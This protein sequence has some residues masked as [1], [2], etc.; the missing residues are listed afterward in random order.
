MTTSAESSA[1]I[2]DELTTALGAQGVLT[3]D[4][5]A[6]R[7]CT[8]WTG[9]YS[10]RP[11]AVLRPADT[12]GVAT[13]VRLC[14]R[15]GLA[16]IPQG[17]H[18][19]LVGGGT[20]DG[21]DQVV[22]SLDRMNRIRA[23]DP[24]GMSMTVEAGCILETVKAAAE[25]QDCFFPL[26]LGAQGSCQIGGNIST[27]AGGLNVL[28]Y[29]MMRD[30]LLGIE[31]VLHD[32]SVFSDLRALRKNNTGPD[33]KQIFVGSEGTLGIVTAA[34]L[35]LFARPRWIETLW[36]STDSIEAMM[37]VYGRFRREGGEFL[38]A[39]ELIPQNCVDLALELSPETPSPDPERHPIHGLVE[40]SASGGPDPGPWLEEMV[41]ALFESGL[42]KNGILAQNAAQAQS[43]WRIRELM[44]EAQQKRGLHLRTDV[45]VP[46]NAIAPF[47][48]E[49]TA[50]L[51]NALPGLTVLAYGHI[52]DGNVHVNALRPAGMDAAAFKPLIP[53]L[54]QDVN[55]VIDRFSG[56]ISAEHGIG[57]A[58]RAALAARLPEEQR[59][60]LAGLK[61]LF[62]P[63]GLLAPGRI[64]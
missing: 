2:L 18:T 36:L 50:V 15:A 32:G 19:G 30:L 34:T 55:A 5:I 23:V 13:A 62:D 7:Y 41:A 10:R 61:R 12:E 64:W 6:E 4:A 11:L 1:G 42:V 27:N 53:G 8:D 63:Q 22:L 17:G 33:L 49:V 40:I 38:S 51:D 60:L 44:V 24:I 56:S 3:G 25:E 21:P 47:V 59:L 9:D 31:V 37:E 54:T 58:K 35:K 26:S 46:V 52:G 45:S 57:V 16:I 29:G 14:A 28:R 43:L 48:R 39:F 20:A